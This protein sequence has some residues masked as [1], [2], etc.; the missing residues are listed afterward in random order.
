[1]DHRLTNAVFDLTRTALWNCVS[2]NG[3]F[4]GHTPRGGGNQKPDSQRKATKTRAPK[5]QPART[6][7]T[8]RRG[9]QTSRQPPGKTEKT[10]ENESPKQTASKREPKVC[11]EA[12]GPRP[13]W[14][15]KYANKSVTAPS[16]KRDGRPCF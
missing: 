1:M 15:H 16:R 10:K 7:T 5:K 3:R 6:E 13:L 9:S 4:A 12:I 8:G 14:E 11:G 2:A